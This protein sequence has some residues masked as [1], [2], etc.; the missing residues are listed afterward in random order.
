[1]ACEASSGVARADRIHDCDML[2]QRQ[3]TGFRIPTDGRIL[4]P[5]NEIH[6]RGQKLL[7]T[8]VAARITAEIVDR[9]VGFGQ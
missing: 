6:V 5:L 1:M 8:C 7:Q 4:G 9:L 2:R 3:F